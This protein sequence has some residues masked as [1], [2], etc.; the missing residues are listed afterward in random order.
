MTLNTV[1]RCR[2]PRS[3]WLLLI[4]PVLL[5]PSLALSAFASTPK[6]PPSPGDTFI[7]LT[8]ALLCFLGACIFSW[9]TLRAGITADDSGLRVRGFGGWKPVRWAEVSDFYETLPMRKR[10]AAAGYVLETASGKVCFSNDWS[11]A[12]ALRELVARNAVHSRVSE[13]GIKGTRATDPWPVVFDYNTRG[14]CWAPRLWLKLFVVFVVY[15]VVQPALQFAATAN[16][17]GWGT[18]LA[19]AALYLL[20]IGSVGLVFL[21]PLAQYRAADRRKAER[22]TVDLNGIVFENGAR[23]LQAAWA[24]VTAYQVVNSHG[25]LFRYVVETRQGEFDFLSS[26]GNAVLLQ[27]IIQHHAVNADVR[28][29]RRYVDK[30]ALGGPVE[31]RGNWDGDALLPLPDTRLSGCSAGNGVSRR[32]LR[33][34]VCRHRFGPASRQRAADWNRGSARYRM[35]RGTSAGLA[36]LQAKRDC[37]RRTRADRADAVR[38]SGFGLGTSAG[39]HTEPRRRQSERARYDYRVQPG[40]CRLYRAATG[41]RSLCCPCSGRANKSIGFV[42]LSGGAWGLFW[43]APR[44][45]ARF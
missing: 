9:W 27:A 20:L 5:C 39:L 8:F 6:G 17:I 44:K 36:G 30:E 14:N 1:V 34:A 24:D 37:G 23:R 13:W 28:E 15:L 43:E 21:L 42:V 2:P 10:S 45:N 26:L 3:N 35:E 29:W 11:N 4:F 25:V 16:M 18:T 31:R 12:E 19:V 33:P 38:E 22:I 41:D 7:L 32:G 40:H